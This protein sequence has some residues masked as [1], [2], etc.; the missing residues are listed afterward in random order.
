[1]TIGSFDYKKWVVE[2]KRGK[3]PSH[4]HYGSLNEQVW[5]TGQ[6]VSQEFLDS[7]CFLCVTGSGNS[8]TDTWTLVGVNSDAQYYNSNYGMYCS[9]MAPQYP[10]QSNA[11]YS[12]GSPDLNYILEWYSGSGCAL[13]ASAAL[14]AA[15][16]DNLNLSGSVPCPTGET[17]IGNGLSV[18]YTGENRSGGN[19][20]IFCSPGNEQ[21]YYDTFSDYYGNTPEDPDFF[22]NNWEGFY[23]NYCCIT[24][25]AE[26]NLP[27]DVD[28]DGVPNYQEADCE[29]FATLPQSFQDG[30]CQSCE[31]PDYMNMHCGCCEGF[32]PSQYQLTGDE[33]LPFVTG[34]AQTGSAQGMPS[35]GKSKPKPKP[36][37]KP[38]PKRKLKERYIRLIKKQ[39]QKLNEQKKMDMFTSNNIACE[40][41]PSNEEVENA[42]AS[43][44]PEAYATIQDK[45]IREGGR[46]GDD[47]WVSF[48][49]RMGWPKGMN[50]G[51]GAYE[52][53]I[54][55]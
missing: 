9:A 13:T 17:D 40:D 39:I 15:G 46:P 8:P 7:E 21:N 42:F 32:E 22:A 33:L 3:A 37:R 41:M 16:S 53:P 27:P 51:Y 2:N 47:R 43:E 54:E 48:F 31:D 6:N 1:M 10:G 30:I 29:T 4:S 26:T 44:N 20:D 34:S 19:Y 55:C 23:I 35:F 14:G 50:L 36:K 52:Y 11:Y 28:S 49:F 24:G 45:Y 5:A 38:R 18:F 25:S 12:N